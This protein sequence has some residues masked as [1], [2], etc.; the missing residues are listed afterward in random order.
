MYIS[1]FYIYQTTT[2]KI[3]VGIEDISTYFEKLKYQ[4]SDHGDDYVIN[5]MYNLRQ[6]T[7]LIDCRS[8]NF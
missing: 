6:K 4:I 5:F 2:T 7:Y 8:N 3:K 1:H